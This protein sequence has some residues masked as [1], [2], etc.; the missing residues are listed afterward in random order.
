[1]TWAP[2]PLADSTAVIDTFL[3]G[4]PLHDR[5]DAMEVLC[6]LQ[7]EV[8]HAGIAHGFP[9]RARD[10]FCGRWTGGW[11][12]DGGSIRWIVDT[13]RANLNRH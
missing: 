5:H 13:V 7:S 2:D 8:S 12:N 6:A 1:M 11:E 9:S 3:A 10:C 4:R